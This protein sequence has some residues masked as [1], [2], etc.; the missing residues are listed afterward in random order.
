MGAVPGLKSVSPPPHPMYITSAGET[1]SCL[2]RFPVGWRKYSVTGARPAL[3]HKYCK[4]PGD[5]DPNTGG[6]KVF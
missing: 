6:K 4:S 1:H 5:R 3:C 2:T